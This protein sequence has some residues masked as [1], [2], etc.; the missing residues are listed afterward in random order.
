L[1][2]AQRRFPDPERLGKNL[3]IPKL[4]AESPG[5]YLLLHELEGNEFKRSKE[6]QP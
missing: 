4:G 3:P 6:R 2:E 5:P 1:R